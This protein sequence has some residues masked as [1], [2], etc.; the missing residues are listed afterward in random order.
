MISLGSD[1][2]FSPQPGQYNPPPPPAALSS[3]QQK[4]PPP[5]TYPQPQQQ[6]SPV[7]DYYL[8]GPQDGALN[9]INPDPVTGPS[10]H[11]H[12]RHQERG[13][14]F[15]MSP[16]GGGTGSTS[17]PTKMP[18]IS[19]LREAAV[20]DLRIQVQV[21]PIKRHRSRAKVEIHLNLEIQSASLF[22]ELYFS[23]PV[24][25]QSKRSGC[26]QQCPRQSSFVS[27]PQP[28]NSNSRPQRC[29]RPAT[30][31]ATPPSAAPA[32]KFGLE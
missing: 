17:S 11:P 19:P 29:H 15:M 25:S 3:P 14:S 32:T 7:K 21:P 12:Q 27:V 13:A 28:T 2:Q 18:Q 1:S 10:H 26:E 20:P 22:N 30:A 31:D 23:V 4:A 16:P 8:K 9:V 6:K 24:S 5:T